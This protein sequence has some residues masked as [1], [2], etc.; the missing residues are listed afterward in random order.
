MS[1]EVFTKGNSDNLDEAIKGLNQFTKNWCMNCKE[2]EEK[3]NL[4]FRCSKCNFSDIGGICKI[5][6][7]VVDKA[8]DMPKDFGSMAR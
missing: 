4:T 8:G 5:K 6:E 2:T 7:F 3:N 1:K